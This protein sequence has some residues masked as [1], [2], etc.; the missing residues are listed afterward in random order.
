MAFDDTDVKYGSSTN[1]DEDYEERLGFKVL[2]EEDLVCSVETDERATQCKLTLEQFYDNYFKAFRERSARKKTLETAIRRAKLPPDEQSKLRKILYQKETEF[3]RLRRLRLSA[4]DFQT[5]RIIGRGAF[6]E[7]RVVVMKQTKEVY[8]MKKLKKSEMI[9][10]DQVLHVR[11]ERQLHADSNTV[12]GHNEW[13]VSLFYSFQDIDYLY[14]ILE[15]V[16]GGDMMT[17][18]INLDTF[19]EEVTQFYIAQTICAIHSVHQLDYIHRDIKPD[20]LLVDKDGHIKLADFGLC[21]GLESSRFA[22]MYKALKGKDFAL[23]SSDY[24]ELSRMKKKETWKKKRRIEARSMVGTPDFIAPEVFMQVGYGKEC[25]WWSVGCIMFEMLIG[26]P[27]FCSDT[28]DETYRKIMNFEETLIFPSDCNISKKARDLIERLICAQSDRLGTKGGIDEIRK[29]PFFDGV[30]WEN[31]RKGKGP[32]QPDL[33]DE[34]DTSLFDEYEETDEEPSTQVPGQNIAFIGYTY[35]SFDAVKARFG[36]FESFFD[37]DELTCD[38]AKKK[39]K[40]RK[41]GRRLDDKK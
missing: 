27:P 16:P 22:Q 17:H 3:I 34:L 13:V 23:Q 5:V 2:D 9:T 6:G 40:E 19:S 36:D 41:K 31:I 25:D 20:N 28:P 1:D 26:Y 37:I 11:N 24:K 4:D 18:L 35:K 39:E 30:D 14:L 29:H 7:V 10:K 32:F 33:K 21:T 12:H 8:A 15:Y 38:V